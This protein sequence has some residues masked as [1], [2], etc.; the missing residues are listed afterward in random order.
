M[1]NLKLWVF[2]ALFLKIHCWD[3]S[4]RFTDIQFCVLTRPTTL[5]SATINRCSFRQNWREYRLTNWAT[6]ENRRCSIWQSALL[7][8]TKRVAGFVIPW[9]LPLLN[10]TKRVAQFDKARCSI[11]QKTRTCSMKNRNQF[12]FM[13]ECNRIIGA[14][15]LS[16]LC[17]FWQL[18]F[19]YTH[20]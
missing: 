11:R 8:L 9:K 12:E 15:F 6:H 19:M 17:N 20:Y 4:L 14:M 1:R 2:L 13:I 18:V 10:L 16:Q 3:L 7:N 5:V